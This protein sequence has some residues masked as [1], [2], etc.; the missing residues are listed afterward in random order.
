MGVSLDPVTPWDLDVGWTP[1]LVVDATPGRRAD[2]KFPHFSG[3]P[4]PSP[5]SAGGEADW[6]GAAH[7]RYLEASPASESSLGLK[8]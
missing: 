6:L 4:C 1:C 8:V 7:H 2:R 3:G 5:V